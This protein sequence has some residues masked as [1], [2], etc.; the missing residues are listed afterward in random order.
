MAITENQ[1]RT[2][3]DP[4]IGKVVPG[5]WL[6]TIATAALA[7]PVTA[8]DERIVVT[9]RMTHE[10]RDYHV[11]IG[12]NDYDCPHQDPDAEMVVREEAAEVEGAPAVVTTTTRLMEPCATAHG[13]GEAVVIASGWAPEHYGPDGIVLEPPRRG[14]RRRPV[15]MSVKA[16]HAAYQDAATLT[17]DGLKASNAAKITAARTAATAD[18]GDPD[19]IDHG[20]VCDRVF[21][22]W[23]AKGVI[24]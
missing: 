5:S 24:E 3:L 20:P 10:P 6:R 14:G 8:G 17:C 19:A 13:A 7:E 12:A 16:F 15:V 22:E 18:G 11:R 4:L 21:D 1:V 2:K 23:K 9:G